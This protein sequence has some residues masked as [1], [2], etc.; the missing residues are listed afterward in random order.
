MAATRWTSLGLAALLCALLSACT[1]SSSPDEQGLLMRLDQDH[2]GIDMIPGWVNVKTLQIHPDSEKPE[3]GDLHVRG[4]FRGWVFHP[5][6]QVEGS[7]Q[8]VPETAATVES[9]LRLS[10]RSVHPRSGAMPVGDLVPGRFDAEN[11]LFYPSQTRLDEGAV[12]PVAPMP[13]DESEDEASEEDESE[14]EEED[15][16]SE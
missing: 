11:A 16:S 1:S 14:T 10:D 3:P 15:A 13:E 8:P 4:A 12:A 7:L 5:Q 2:E 9:W 6:G